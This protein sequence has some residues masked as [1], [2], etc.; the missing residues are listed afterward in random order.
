MAPQSTASEIYQAESS[1][2]TCT[3]IPLLQSEVQSSSISTPYGKMEDDQEHQ[4]CQQHG[5]LSQINSS[6][7]C[8]GVMIGLFI[9]FSTLGANFLVLSIWG[10]EIVN[11][12][13]TEI[14]V[15][16]LLWSLC[17][18]GMAVAVLIF[19][20]K[21]VS[22]TYSA[23]SGHKSENTDSGKI[24]DVIDE[25]IAQVECRFI[26]GSLV[27]VCVAWSITDYLLGMREQIVYSIATLIVALIW[28]KGMT[29]LF[30]SSKLS[31]AVDESSIV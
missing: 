21:L 22:T 5:P 8:L 30:S 16:S 28:C 1:E 3:Q 9:Q 7:L 20:R 26:V 31:D 19:L 15:F 2:L 11:K 25:M 14:V 24:E 23:L 29:Y 10:S 18:S 4:D 27:G 6:S 13:K 17:T 12:T